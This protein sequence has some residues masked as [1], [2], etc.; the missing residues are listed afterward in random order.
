MRA[1]VHAE[2]TEV[3]IR[4]ST[5]PL[6]PGIGTLH[7]LRRAHS[8]G[9]RSVRVAPH[10][11]EADISAQHIDAARGLGMDV[12]GFLMMSHRPNSPTWPASPS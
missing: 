8:P 5:T 9:I 7:D 10:C 3:A 2:V 12:A 1:T 4:L 6:P 11:T